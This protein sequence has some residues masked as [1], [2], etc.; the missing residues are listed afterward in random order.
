MHVWSTSHFVELLLLVC[1]FHP[2]KHIKPC[3]L[4]HTAAKSAVTLCRCAAHGELPSHAPEILFVW[5]RALAQKEVSWP[6]L[7]ARDQTRALIW[8]ENGEGGKIWRKKKKAGVYCSCG[9]LEVTGMER[10]RFVKMK[11]KTDKLFIRAETTGTTLTAPR[12]LH[13]HSINVCAL[14]PDMNSHTYTQNLLKIPSGGWLGINY[15]V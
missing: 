2:Y 6:W 5:A 7:S 8:K 10:T 14:E 3:W 15:P 4:Y 9:C 1:K 12:E 13:K 11:H